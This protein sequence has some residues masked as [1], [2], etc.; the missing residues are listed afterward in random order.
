MLCSIESDVTRYVINEFFN[1]IR[2]KCPML[3]LRRRSAE[4]NL[5]KRHIIRFRHPTISAHMGYFETARA[6]PLVKG[7]SDLTWLPQLS[8]YS[9]RVTLHRLGANQGTGTQYAESE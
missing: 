3:D 4:S 7:P 2:P 9:E 8:A 5:Y 1:R 6:A